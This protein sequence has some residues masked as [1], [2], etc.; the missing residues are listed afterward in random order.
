MEQDLLSPSVA[1]S[2]ARGVASS[3]VNSFANRSSQ[4]DGSKR[5]PLFA[6]SAI[7]HQNALP[8]ELLVT[9]YAI[10]GKKKSS[11]S[12]RDMQMRR[13]KTFVQ[14]VF[15]E[16]VNKFS[17]DE[18]QTLLYLDFYQELCNGIAPNGQNNQSLHFLHR[19]VSPY[20]ISEQNGNPNQPKLRHASLKSRF[21]KMAHKRV[22]ALRPTDHF[23]LSCTLSSLWEQAV[24]LVEQ[25]NHL[26]STLYEIAE[27]LVSLGKTLPD[28]FSPLEEKKN[29]VHISSFKMT[30]KGAGAKL[31]ADQSQKIK[32]FIE[33]SLL[34][35]YEYFGIAKP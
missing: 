35:G 33:I 6:K 28:N 19:P 31:K 16:L 12:P 15:L 14:K 4:I 11:K 10:I 2:I 18:L 20:F 30:T 32:E 26:G 22:I 5:D 7:E 24:R 27:K 29:L 25:Q 13:K 8:D 1:S 3:V 17:E 23:Q 21:L 34:F 9:S